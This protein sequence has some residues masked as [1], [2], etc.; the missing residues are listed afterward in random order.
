MKQKYPDYHAE[1]MNMSADV[2]EAHGRAT[3]WML[4]RITG[5]GENV[6]RESLT[7]G[8]WKRRKGQWVAYKQTG[9]RGVGGCMLG[10][11]YE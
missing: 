6:Q 10:V 11:D 8:Y 7:I 4:L 2:D 1:E 3:V 9:L 5:H